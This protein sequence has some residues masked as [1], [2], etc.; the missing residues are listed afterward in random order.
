MGSEPARRRGRPPGRVTELRAPEGHRFN[1]ETRIGWLLR[2]WRLAVQPQSN[3]RGF[4]SLLADRGLSADASRLSR[5]ETGRLPAPMEIIAGYEDV[6][7]LPPGDLVATAAFHRRMAGRDARGRA[8]VAAQPDSAHVEALLDVVVDGEPTGRD[9]FDFGLVA[10]TLGEQLVLPRSVWRRVTARL[11]REM[12]LS[13]R[14]AYLSREEGAILLSSHPTA[15]N[16]LVYAVGENV[17][18]PGNLLVTDP[19]A[20]LEEIEGPQANDLVLRLLGQSNR[21]LRNAAAW[22]AA[23]KVARGHFDA[24][25]MQRLEHT[26]IRQAT[27]H[28]LHDIG[29]FGRL[30]DLVAVLPTDAQDRVRHGLHLPPRPAAASPTDAVD[31]AVLQRVGRPGGQVENPIFERLATL[32]LGHREPERRFLAAWTLY[33]SPTRAVFARQCA[34]QLA[35]H[36]AGEHSLDPEMLHRL[37]M[38]LSVA[39]TAEQAELLASVLQSDHVGL[40]PMALLALAHLPDTSPVAEADLAHF[41]ADPDDA[42]ARTALYCAGMTGRPV[43][44]ELEREDSLPRWRRDAA[45]WWWTHGPAIREPARAESNGRQVS[46]GR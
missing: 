12:G 27:R 21:A 41:V 19:M 2:G 15:R 43:L 7:G 5:W 6:L 10:C 33:A 31:A 30:A 36:L 28:G 42:L 39:G 26:V 46:R 25:E 34:T 22:A 16:A 8:A 20:L 4:A 1:A 23:G 35:G 3:A 29:S 24:A 18:L 37:L 17:T 32:A 14:N 45:H 40:R 11:V 9:W 13:L 44:A 38:A